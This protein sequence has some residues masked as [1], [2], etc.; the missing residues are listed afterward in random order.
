[1]REIKYRGLVIEPLASG[2]KWISSDEEYHEIYINRVEKTAYINGHEVV[3]ESVSEYTGLKDKN[4]N[5]IYLGDIVKRE[6][7]IYQTY[8]EGSIEGNDLAPTQEIEDAGYF[9]GVVSQT[10][11]GLYVLNKCS[12][13]NDDDEFVKKRSNV[14]LFAH[15]AE[16]IGNIHENQELLESANEKV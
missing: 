15:R 5:E 4:G 14:K 11:S 7:E 1:M 9:I 2:E 6:F 16:V 12:K 3:Y 8:W 10:P 13:F